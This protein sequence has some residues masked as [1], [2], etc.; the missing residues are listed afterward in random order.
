M[1]IWHFVSK[2]LQIGTAAFIQEYYKVFP[3]GCHGLLTF[4][5]IDIW[6]QKSDYWS[7]MQA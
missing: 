3:F 2:Y 7:T 6:H 4:Q 5:G 1:T